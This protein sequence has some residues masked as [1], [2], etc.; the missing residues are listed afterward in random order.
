MARKHEYVS[1]NIGV[2]KKLIKT[3]DIS[4]RLIIDYNIYNSYK[5]YKSVKSKMTRY[6]FVAEDNGCSVATVIRAVK[7]MESSC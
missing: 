6:Q 1:K 5:A 2:I 3:G 7:N 4:S